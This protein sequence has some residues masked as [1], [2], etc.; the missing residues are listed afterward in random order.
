VSFAAIGYSPSLI[1][2][3]YATIMEQSKE[4][5]ANMPALTIK[6]IPDNLYDKLKK[7][8]NPITEA[9]TVKSFTVLKP[10]LYLKKWISQKGYKEPKS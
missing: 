4:R 10:F 8:L 5:E 1:C 9:S 3:H 2:N 6:N 7:R